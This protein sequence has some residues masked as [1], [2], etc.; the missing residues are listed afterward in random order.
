MRSGQVYQPRSGPR[1]YAG[2]RTRRGTLARI[3]SRGYG[4][5]V[6]DDEPE[7]PPPP[8][9]LEFWLRDEDQLVTA[10]VLAKLTDLDGELV[11]T[12]LIID[13]EP[14][15]SAELR[16]IPVSRIAGFANRLFYHRERRWM[17]DLAAAMTLPLPELAYADQKITD[18]LRWTSD[19][20]RNTTPYPPGYLEPADRPKRQPLARPNGSDPDGFSRRVAEAYNEVVFATRRPAVALAEEAGVPVTTV[21]RW[22]RE[23]RRRGYLPPAKRGR[24]G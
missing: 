8:Y 23:A 20:Y 2:L 5:G 21:H 4:A 14:I 12:R 22:I 6:G 13:G 11:L 19:E 7:Y 3:S 10:R 17:D 15:D 1:K 24:A 9:W 18:Y 16:R